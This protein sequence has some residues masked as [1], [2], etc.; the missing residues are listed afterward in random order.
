MFYNHKT[1]RLLS[2]FLAAASTFALSF[3]HSAAKAQS[4]PEPLLQVA[5]TKPGT[6]V[7][8]QAKQATTNSN[9]TEA[10]LKVGETRSQWL[11]RSQE[12]TIARLYP[13]DLEGREAV[14][15]F[16]RDIPVMTFLG[17]PDL[18]NPNR[19]TNVAIARTPRL[20]LPSQDTS[21]DASRHLLSAPEPMARGMAVAALINQLG[22]EGFDASQIVPA[23][24]KGR[25]TIKFGDRALYNFDDRTVLAGTTSNRQ[26]DLLI[27]ANRLRRLLGNADPVSAIENAP[28]SDISRT[29]M[30]N[31]ARMLTGLAS[32]YGPGLHGGSSASGE[33]FDQ[34]A[35][36]AAH[37]SLPFGTFVRVT[38]ITNGKSV[39]VR[40]ND[41]GPF[42]PRRIIDLSRAAARTIGLISSGVAPVRMEILPNA[43]GLP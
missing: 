30:G 33:K 14:T 11:A 1:G 18:P 21:E 4:A 10:V 40:I 17:Q 26:Q 13:H 5:T 7:S 29:L 43:S 16:V 27:A 8:G 9:A 25:Y 23:W 31:A 35:F 22:R 38:N 42:S 41:R 15:L 6:G 28:Q 39:I 12:D 20:K 19:K 2:A 24:E 36:T 37:R 3:F 32:W 34:F